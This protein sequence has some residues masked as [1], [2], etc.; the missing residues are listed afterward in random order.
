MQINGKPPITYKQNKLQRQ[1]LPFKG[2]VSKELMK[3]LTKEPWY[4]RSSVKFSQVGGENFANIVNSAGKFAIAP[5]VIAFNPLSKEKKE[6]KVYSAWKQ[7]IEAV[8]TLASQIIALVAFDKYVDK[9]AY[10]GK[11]AQQF[12]LN[13]VTDKQ[14]LKLTKEKLGI[15]KDRLGFAI[16][17][18]LIPLTTA[19]SNWIYPKIM[20]KI[21]PQGDKKQ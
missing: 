14:V 10:A 20:K 11:L 3:K 12:N 17:L 9:L 4:I 13:K 18:L 15:F 1:N 19:A 2:L 6:T 7:P 21:L 5:L 8:I 16:S